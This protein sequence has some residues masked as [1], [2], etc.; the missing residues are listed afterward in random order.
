V[1]AVALVV[2]VVSG[3]SGF[4]Y[5][6]VGYDVVR[7]PVASVRLKQTSSLSLSILPNTGHA[8]LPEG[9]VIVRVKGEGVRVLSPLLHREDAV[10]P[11]AEAPRFE[12]K[13]SGEKKGPA[14]V[15]AHCVFYVC[16]DTRCRAIET[17][18]RWDLDVAP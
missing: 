15:N 16:K 14:W 6:E 8:L 3:L 7:A 13:V 12:I 10:D 5:A 18:A 17:D 2:S 9:P 11:R 1:R 4:A